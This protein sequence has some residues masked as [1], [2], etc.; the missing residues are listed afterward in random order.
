M[1]N[2][3]KDAGIDR[4]SRV[5]ENVDVQ[6]ESDDDDT[7][8]SHRLR[9]SHKSKSPVYCLT[10]SV[11]VAFGKVAMGYFRLPPR[12]TYLLGSLNNNEVL[13]RVRK[14]RQRR[15]VDRNADEAVKT[16][17]KELGTAGGAEHKDANSTLNEVERIDHILRK[18]FKKTK[19]TPICFYTFIVHPHSFSRTVENIFYVAFLVK[20]GYAKISL[21]DFNLP[22]I[23]KKTLEC[24][25][26]ELYSLGQIKIDVYHL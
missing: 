3:V 10:G 15:I 9:K 7:V 13:V 23:G 21:D 8:Q 24:F 12:P 14:I 2:C 26:L 1:V 6:E 16:K 18:L 22:V 20:D 17:V 25:Q 4:S 5:A 19:S 11:L